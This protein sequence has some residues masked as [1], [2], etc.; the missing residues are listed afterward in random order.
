[1][2]ERGKDWVSDATRRVWQQRGV[3]V[4]RKRSRRER[5]NPLL[6]WIQVYQREENPR[7]TD[8]DQDNRLDTPWRTLK[9]NA[10][11]EEKGM[12]PKSIATLKFEYCI[13]ELKGYVFDLCDLDQAE[14]FNQDIKGITNYVDREIDPIAGKSL[15]YI[16]IIIFRNPKKPKLAQV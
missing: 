16:N 10:S 13:E 1:M 8:L 9:Q 14:R 12:Y 7:L 3:A 5:L 15:S 4:N 2:K 11:I 6:A